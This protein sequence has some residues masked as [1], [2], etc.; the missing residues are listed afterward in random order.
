VKR[1]PR[2]FYSRSTLTVARELLGQRLVRS[3]DGQRLAG[4]IVEVEAY[5]GETDQASHA[6]PGR[7]RRNA[8]MYGPPGHAY[9]YFIYGMYYCLNAVTEAEGSAAAVLIRALEPLEGIDV[10]RHHRPGRADRD[11][12]SGPGKL[13]QALAIDRTLNNADLCRGRSLWIEAATPV[14]DAQATTSPRIGVR[15]DKRARTVP[16]RF[17]IREHPCLS[18]QR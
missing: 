2:E 17:Y 3:F 12:A 1:L 9:I 15:G 4:R 8:P 11:L 13:C 16:W 18:H 6:R 14:P 10:M 7:T 5:L